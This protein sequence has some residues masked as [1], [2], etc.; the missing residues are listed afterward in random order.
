MQ[1]TPATS[2]RRS[3]NRAGASEA[4]TAFRGADRRVGSDGHQGGREEDPPLHRVL[5]RPVKPDPAGSPEADPR[6]GEGEH[7][8]PCEPDVA[9]RDLGRVKLGGI[10]RRCRG[11]RSRSIAAVVSEIERH[12]WGDP[13]PRQESSD[14]VT[15]SEER[16][17]DRDAR[18]RDGYRGHSERHVGNHLG[19]EPTHLDPRDQQ[20]HGE[21][22]HEEERTRPHRPS[23][24]HASWTH[25]SPI[26]LASPLV[27]VSVDHAAACAST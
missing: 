17:S 12:P 25:P 4:T 1:P 11:G 21:C 19:V 3:T 13:S 5:P 9:S 6:D 22:R 18:R 16:D 15:C 20:P 27:R 24:S 7:Q 14:E 8:R 2:K 23:T 26:S 10:E